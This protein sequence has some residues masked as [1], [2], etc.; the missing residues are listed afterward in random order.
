M[1]DVVM[2]IPV[3]D[4]GPEKFAAIRTHLR[5]LGLQPHHIPN[6]HKELLRLFEPTRVPG[7][8]MYELLSF[9]NLYVVHDF[10]SRSYLI[11]QRR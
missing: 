9:Y 4:P 7:T 2:V 1:T 3:R 6:T 8:L 5:L 10:F 11:R